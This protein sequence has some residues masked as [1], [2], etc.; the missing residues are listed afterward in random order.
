MT[1]K[2]FVAIL[3]LSRAAVSGGKILRADA[4]DFQEAW[5]GETLRIQGKIRLN[6]E[7]GLDVA[8]AET[9][10]C[11]PRVNL[12]LGDTILLSQRVETFDDGTWGALDETIAVP[13]NIPD[14]HTGK[15]KVHFVPAF[16]PYFA[17]LTV[18]SALQISQLK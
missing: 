17:I 16:Q 18:T 4:I 1:M 10:N 15:P 6:D 9:N 7:L 11:A 14:E 2:L 12:T 5:A 3:L 13:E 8:C